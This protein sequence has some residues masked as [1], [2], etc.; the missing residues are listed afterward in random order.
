MILKPI[1]YRDI[2][3][4]RR[5]ARETVGLD[6]DLPTALIMFGGYGSK[7]AEKIVKRL[8][9]AKLPLQT[10]VICGHN[11]K[12]RAALKDRPGCHAVGFTDRVPDYMRMAD[13]FIGKPG[14]GSISEA[15]HMGLP[16]I[17]E[18]NN[19]TMPQERYNTDWVEER[20]VGVVIRD[21]RRI[22]E[23][24]GFL[25]TDGRLERFRENARRLNNRAVYEIPVMLERIIE[26][27]A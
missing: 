9:R 3:D 11:E 18:R 4:D 13:F 23:S 20:E 21:F 22:A 10:I 26:S 8:T 25:L 12:L 15:L 17:I 16:V 2:A 5:A 7:T 6:P 19:L 24:V 27:A 14:P 1:F